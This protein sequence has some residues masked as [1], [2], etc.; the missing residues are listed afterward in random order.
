MLAH[1]R[2]LAPQAAFLVA[3]AER[4]PFAAGAFHL[5]TA[6]GSINYTDRPRSLAEAARVLAPAGTMAIYDFSAG[7]R[8]E[9]CTPLAYVSS[10]HALRRRHDAP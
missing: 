4:L 1:G 9:A 8:P 7:R 3:E 5:I 6:A 10:L 2:T